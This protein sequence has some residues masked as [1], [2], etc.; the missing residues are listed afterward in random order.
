[1]RRLFQES[2]TQRFFDRW[3]QVL[4]CGRAP[5]HLGELVRLG[6]GAAGLLGRAR[7]LD[8]Q[9]KRGQPAIDL[10]VVRARQARRHPA[11]EDPPLG[12]ALHVL[13]VLDSLMKDRPEGLILSSSSGK[14]R[15]GRRKKPARLNQRDSCR[16]LFSRLSA[17][18]SS[19][20]QQARKA[21][22]GHWS[23]G[24]SS[25]S[26]SRFT[27]RDGPVSSPAPSERRRRRAAVERQPDRRHRRFELGLFDHDPVGLI[28][29]HRSAGGELA[30][31]PAELDLEPPAATVGA[32]LAPQLDRADLGH[33]RRQADRHALGLRLAAHAHQ[34]LQAEEARGSSRGRPARGP[35]ACRR[36]GPSCWRA[37]RPRAGPSRGRNR[38]R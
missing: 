15:P 33:A 9:E 2:I 3:R 1:M 13:G 34:A 27:S 17:S 6:L 10:V 35:P 26:S 28:A 37:G 36:A 31:R 4:E 25:T 21:D 23:R 29:G 19:G 8:G 30:G 38:G 11:P 24:T 7:P 22:G 12:P 20:S 18:S 5:P 16:G 14:P 32:R